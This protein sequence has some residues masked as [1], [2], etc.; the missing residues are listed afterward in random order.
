MME[1]IG[2]FVAGII[3]GIIIAWPMKQEEPKKVVSQLREKNR[4]LQKKVL[5]L[6]SALIALKRREKELL[7][8][9]ESIHDH[10]T[11]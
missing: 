3:I 7:T 9:L 8:Q 6:A 1:F 5:R 4:V 10:H 2:V 11:T